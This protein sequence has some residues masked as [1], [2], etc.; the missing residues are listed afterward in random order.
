MRSLRAEPAPS[1]WADIPDRIRV[2]LEREQIRS[3]ADWL[4]L[5]AKARASIF[6]V[7]PGIQ[8]ML[9]ETARR[10]RP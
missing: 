1:K 5:S 6:G 4:A 10:A 8:R 9:T 2:T 3:G 7:P